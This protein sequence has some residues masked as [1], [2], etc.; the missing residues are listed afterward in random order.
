[1]KQSCSDWMYRVAHSKV[2]HTRAVCAYCQPVIHN[3]SN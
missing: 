1:M 3:S 2:A